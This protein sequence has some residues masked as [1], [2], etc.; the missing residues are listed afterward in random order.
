MPLMKLSFQVLPTG[1]VHFPLPLWLRIQPLPLIHILIN[2]IA[3]GANQLQP[4]QPTLRDFQ[5]IYIRQQTTVLEYS[6]SLDDGVGQLWGQG[7]LEMQRH[8]EGGFYSGG[9]SVAE[10]L[11]CRCVPAVI[12]ECVAHSLLL[13]LFVL[14]ERT[15]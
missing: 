8:L 9:Y 12:A 13:L 5:R 10:D 7:G 4:N 1:I 14:S 3:I 15:S 6:Q 11:A 2:S